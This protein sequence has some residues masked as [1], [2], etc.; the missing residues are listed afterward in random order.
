MNVDQGLN[1]ERGMP[2]RST[3]VVSVIVPAYN[4]GLTLDLAL[5][6]IFAQTFRDFEV[7]VIDDG[8]TDDTAARLARWADRVIVHRQTN[9]GPAHARNQGLRLS[10]GRLI[11]FLDADDV[12]LPRKLERQVAYFEQF[13]ETG[14]SHTDAIVSSSPAAVLADMP[15]AVPLDTV[16]SAPRFQFGVLFHETHINTL[17]VMIRRDVLADVG[18]FDERRE[19]H[20]E[21][22]DLWL[23]IAA[24]YPIG[25]VPVPLAVRRPAGAMSSAIEKTFRGQQLVIEKVA[26]LCGNACERH[27]GQPEICLHSR[28]HRLYS[29]LGYM[30]FWGGDA[31]GARHAFR[32]ALALR[33]TDAGAWGYVGA[34]W[35]GNRAISL[36]RRFRRLPEPITAGPGAEPKKRQ[37][38]VHDTAFR[39]ARRAVTRKA[40]DTD[41]AITHATRR[42]SRVLFEAASPMSLAVFQPVLDRLE[43]DARLQFWFTTCDPRW[44]PQA[45]FGG[46]GHRRII[47]ASR[48]SWMNFDAYINTDFWNTSWPRRSARRVHL[49]HGVAGKYD[50]DAPVGVAP[51]LAAYDCLMF[52]NRDR[53]SR[54]V[55]AGLVDADSP[56]AALVGYPKVDCLVDGTLDR[57]AIQRELGLDPSLPTV[58]YAPTWSAYSSLATM[59]DAV[60]DA[61]CRLGVNV[62]VK[63]HDRSIDPGRRASLD[64]N[65]R[66][67]S[68]GGRVYLAQGPNASPYMFVADA[69]V[70]D[71][72]SVGFEFMLLDRPLVV[73]DCP[74]LLEHARI[75]RQKADL[76]RS[77]ADVVGRADDLERI[78]SAAL[79][80][81]ERHSDRRK[82][83]ANELFYCAGSATSRAVACIYDLLSLPTPD[84]RA[85]AEA[86]EFA[87]SV[88]NLARTT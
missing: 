3:P 84:P 4:S 63:L 77:A 50:L 38:L 79:A 80:S 31:M 25:Y 88:P 64:W 9:H 52:P 73:I 56:R 42:H 74:D 53:L 59:G 62:V 10:C 34:S 24:R 58:L 2:R 8:S 43:R 39:R 85:V 5:E 18:T 81:P 26:P 49:F 32:Q 6:S 28:M 70:T 44:T 23:R 41:H 67:A 45:I 36:I 46:N 40:H 35:I 22:W 37:N 66:L 82:M 69:M 14:L 29:Q 71:H 78:V 57:R 54:Y 19:V 86:H 48:S 61:L 12:W 55:E 51:V 72:S 30:R 21:D 27:L 33:P 15:D 7:V 60:V 83:I 47:P 13:P 65:T 16:G 75:N 68:R 76:L 87:R 11:A 17:T 1:S 20:V